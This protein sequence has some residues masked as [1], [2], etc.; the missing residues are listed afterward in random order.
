[1]FHFFR[2]Q[3]SKASITLQLSGLHCTACSLTIDESLE[4][5]EGVIKSRTSYAT[6]K[7]VITYD[8]K[9]IGPS[10]FNPVIEKL[11]YRVVK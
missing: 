2:P 1:M 3:R 6:Q 10:A 8:A 11:G 5:L 9:L 4:G 7:C